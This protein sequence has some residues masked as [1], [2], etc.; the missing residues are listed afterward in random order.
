MKEEHPLREDRSLS[1]LISRLFRRKRIEPVGAQVLDWSKAISDLIDSG[2]LSTVH[3]A[4]YSPTEQ[5]MLYRTSEAKRNEVQSWVGSTESGSAIVVSRGVSGNISELFNLMKNDEVFRRA[6][7][8]LSDALE[9]FGRLLKLPD[10]HMWH[11]CMLALMFERANQRKT[12]DV[13]VFLYVS[14][15]FYQHSKIEEHLNDVHSYLSAW[16]E[17]FDQDFGP[18]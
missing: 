18:K 12:L 13:V 2:N 5:L 17:E 8:A 6:V 11:T 3:F 4:S 16:F 7:I 9:Q 1:R 15:I 10:R 14:D